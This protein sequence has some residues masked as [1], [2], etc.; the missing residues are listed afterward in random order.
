MKAVE[1]SATMIPLS[2]GTGLLEKNAFQ[3]PI[4]LMPNG[5]LQI[6]DEKQGEL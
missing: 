2:V 4:A 3:Q 6:E 1:K 5:Q